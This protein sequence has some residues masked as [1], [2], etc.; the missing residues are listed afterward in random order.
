MRWSETPTCVPKRLVG[1]PERRPFGVRRSRGRGV[2]VADHLTPNTTG[3]SNHA[4]APAR[5]QPCDDPGNRAG[6]ADRGIHDDAGPCLGHDGRILD[7]DPLLASV[8]RSAE[9]GLR[10]PGPDHG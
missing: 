5:S 3:G 1:T 8:R 4:D 10:R 2:T 7:G 9:L 6:Y